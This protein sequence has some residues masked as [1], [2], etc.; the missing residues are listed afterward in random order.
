MGP[1][2]NKVKLVSILK[3]IAII[4]VL[5][6]HF[7]GNMGKVFGSFYGQIPVFLRFSVPVFFLVSG[8][9]IDKKYSGKISDKKTII[10][11]YK[12]RF[13]KILIPYFLFT[14]IYLA[15]SY[16]SF[17]SPSHYIGNFNLIMSIK[18]MLI[19]LP[20]G[21]LFSHLYF[22]PAILSFY[23][24]YPLI[25]K[26]NNK[27]GKVPSI[28]IFFLVYFLSEFIF[29][30]YFNIDSPR[31]LFFHWIPYFSMGIFLNGREQSLQIK[32]KSIMAISI[33]IFLISIYFGNQTSLF[34]VYSLLTLVVGL[35]Y[36]ISTSKI[37]WLKKSLSHLGDNSYSVYLS[38]MLITDL[39][40]FSWLD[41]DS[42]PVIGGFPLFILVILASLVIGRLVFRLIG[43]IEST[44]LGKVLK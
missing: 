25:L 39:I 20:T 7:Y 9:L 13:G 2:N 34:Y 44:V 38:H 8:Y 3:G 15:Y 5:G 12:R 42:V 24:T 22:V 32:K 14:L 30:R 43:I 18:L 19:S 35:S 11:F 1:K 6:I 4:G 33:V 10:K 21:F 37:L 28:F 31:W 40:Y 16:S 29:I 36:L 23:L 41:S 26:I 17:S 27:I